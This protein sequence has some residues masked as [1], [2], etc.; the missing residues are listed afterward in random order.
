MKKAIQKIIAKVK[1]TFNLVNPYIA[2][3]ILVITVIAG[4]II[5]KCTIHNSITYLMVISSAIIFYI[6]RENKKVLVNLL[7]IFLI[8]F[9]IYKINIKSFDS[10]NAGLLSVILQGIIYRFKK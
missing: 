3:I 2:L 5:S 4:V 7:S 9:I 8:Y 1:E 6:Y 10:I